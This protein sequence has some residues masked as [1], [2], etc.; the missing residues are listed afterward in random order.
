[1]TGW[2][3]TSGQSHLQGS[4]RPRMF[5]VLAPDVVVPDTEWH[6][7]EPKWAVRSLTGRLASSAIAGA[8]S[9]AARPSWMRTNEPSTGPSPP[10][11][12]RD[13][14]PGPWPRAVALSYRVYRSAN[15]ALRLIGTNLSLEPGDDESGSLTTRTSCVGLLLRRCTRC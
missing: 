7:D 4:T 5:L 12:K 14:V 1:M 9:N 10:L 15:K 8:S 6:S 13:R 3:T 11:M 2:V